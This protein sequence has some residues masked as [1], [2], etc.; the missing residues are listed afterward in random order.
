MVKRYQNEKMYKYKCRTNH[1]DYLMTNLLISPNAFHFIFILSLTHY[2]LNFTHLMKIVLFYLI[3]FTLVFLPL[4]TRLLGFTRSSSLSFLDSS[5]DVLN[6]SCIRCLAI[7]EL[8]L[9]L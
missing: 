8:F 5:Y 2:I 9:L 6:P 4:L 1:N 3:H 7:R